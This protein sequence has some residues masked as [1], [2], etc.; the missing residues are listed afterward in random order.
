MPRAVLV[1]S[2]ITRVVILVAAVVGFAVQAQAAELLLYRRLGCPWCRA[3]DETIGPVYPKT[4]LGRR[5]P[6]RHVDLDRGAPLA[7]ALVKPVFFTPTF[8][9][10]DGGREVG[11]IEGYPGEDFFWGLLEKLAR[12][13]PAKS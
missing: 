13:L 2:S 6:L 9:L 8:V 5:L 4:D 1:S 3:F 7:A 10:V 12:A 11:R